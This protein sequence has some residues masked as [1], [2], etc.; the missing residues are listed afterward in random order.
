MSEKDTAAKTQP[1]ST[2]NVIMLIVVAVLAI[3]ILLSSIFS[4]TASTTE[5]I[6]SYSMLG[7]IGILFIILILFRA[8]GRMSVP[9]PRKTFTM[10]Q[11]TKCAFKKIRDFQLGD[12][13]PKPE[14]KCP[15]CGGSIIIEEI[16]PEAEIKKGFKLPF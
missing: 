15:S 7:G 5:N 3:V 13:I 6:L 10:L 4:P 1:R 9:Q 12:Y 14:G 16:Y 8:V 2:V 11:C